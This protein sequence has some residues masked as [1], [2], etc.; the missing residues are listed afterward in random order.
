MIPG[1]VPSVETAKK[2][3]QTNRGSNRITSSY[4]LIF[5]SVNIGN[6]AFSNTVQP[7]QLPSD[8]FEPFNRIKVL[9]LA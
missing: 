6:D 7:F 1:V 3:V 5:P 8:A 2:E 9:V 4:S